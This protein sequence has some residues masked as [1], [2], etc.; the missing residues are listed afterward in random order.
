[1]QIIQITQTNCT[2]HKLLFMSGLN[3][4]EVWFFFSYRITFNILISQHL[5]TRK[6]TSLLS[7]AC[8]DLKILY[9][10]Y[11]NL[12]FTNVHLLQGALKTLD[13]LIL[14]RGLQKL[15]DFIPSLSL[16]R[17]PYRTLRTSDLSICNLNFLYVAKCLARES[18][19]AHCAA[20]AV[21]AP[22]G[23]SCRIK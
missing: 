12:C 9:Y 10:I 14:T 19:L 16:T 4:L 23:L 6:L 22:T 21:Y 20:A 5:P 2:F 11:K 7:A 18:D 3:T 1:M 8:N 13:L 17:S 15:F